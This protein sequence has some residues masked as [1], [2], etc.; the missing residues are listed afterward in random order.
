MAVTASA[1]NKYW[2]H[3]A[4]QLIARLQNGN[5]KM[6]VGSGG[7]D[8]CASA[9]KTIIPDQRGLNS[10]IISLD[11]LDTYKDDPYTVV[12]VARLTQGLMT[13]KA[14]EAALTVEGSAWFIRNFEP[15]PVYDLEYFDVK[16]IIPFKNEESD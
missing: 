2:S 3:L 1:T 11:L 9:P 13:V 12:A 14:S 4:D 16:I 7:W 6:I 10:P 5:V 8:D 15:V